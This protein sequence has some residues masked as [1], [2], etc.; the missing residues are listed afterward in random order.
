MK[1]LVV[2]DTSSSFVGALATL[3]AISGKEIHIIDQ[4]E[5]DNNYVKNG[6]IP[7]KFNIETLPMRNQPLRPMRGVIPTKYL[8]SHHRRRK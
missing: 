8:Q 5:F 6:T 7:P 2:E 3:I 1:I 4:K